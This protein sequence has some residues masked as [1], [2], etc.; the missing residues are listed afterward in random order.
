[1]D[2]HRHHGGPG[3]F[4]GFILGLLVG[5]GLVFLFGT[6]KGKKVLQ[7]L[8]EQVEENTELSDLLEIPE[9]EEE[10]YFDA[11]EED[12]EEVSP[13]GTSFSEEDE[14]ED[15]E[16]PVH[17]VHAHHQEKKTSVKP[18]AKIKRFFRGSPKKLV[19]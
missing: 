9:G 8:L 12:S 17:E 18:V 6:S 13:R 7:M 4:N 5:A 1:M 11:I 3:F 15:E 2:E 19:S 14:V 16:R 10:E